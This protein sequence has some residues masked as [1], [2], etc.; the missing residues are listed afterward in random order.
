MDILP[1]RNSAKAIIINEGKI[2]LTKNQDED[3]YFYLCPGGGQEQGEALKTTVSREC[4]E[5]IGEQV[6]IGDLCFVRDYIGKNHEHSFDF[7]VHRVEFYFLCS[8]ENKLNFERK[9]TN[10]DHHQIGIEWVHF[11]QINQY[12]VYPKQLIRHIKKHF[13]GEKT[14]V[15]VGDIN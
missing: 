4:M 2:L 9:P 7:D 10:P 15:Y 13:N 12:R 8:L 3:G 14:Q 1:I 11:N 5:E 6:T